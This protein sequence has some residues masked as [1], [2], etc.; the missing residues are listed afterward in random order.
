MYNIQ[1]IINND[2]YY[3]FNVAIVHTSFNS[4]GKINW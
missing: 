1:Y 4:F 3:Y 2:N